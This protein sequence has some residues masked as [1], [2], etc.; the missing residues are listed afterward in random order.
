VG[1]K[2]ILG[3]L[4]VFAVVGGSCVLA[5][6]PS[7]DG[8]A[9]VGA[10]TDALPAGA[11]RRFGTTRLR[12]SGA[13]S[14]LQ[15][16]RDGKKLASGAGGIVHVWEAGSWRELGHFAALQTNS[17]AGFSPDG[18][19]IAVLSPT[20]PLP[21]GG[22]PGGWG[23]NAAAGALVLYDVESGRLLR[24]LAD[25]NVTHFAFDGTGSRLIAGDVFGGVTV[26]DA[27]GGTTVAALTDK[28]PNR[29]KINSVWQVA[30]SPDGQT[31]VSVH[32]NGF[33]ASI[34]VWDVA[35]HGERLQ[36]P[37]LQGG[38]LDAAF[39]ADGNT[40]YTLF[41][42]RTG[43]TIVPASLGL[44][45]LDVTRGNPVKPIPPSTIEANG[46]GGFAL[47]AIGGI[48]SA[49][50]KHY[51]FHALA[52]KHDGSFSP[53]LLH[54]VSVVDVGS[55]AVTPME[56]K[57]HGAQAIAFSPAGD[58]LVAGGTDGEIAVW[59]TGTGKRVEAPGPTGA[60]HAVS[61]SPDGQYVAAAGADSLIHVM[62]FA[63]GKEV[64]LWK[65]HENTVL[66][67]SFS[68]DGKSL[69]SAGL[70]NAVRIWD[71]ASGQSQVIRMDRFWQPTQ[72]TIAWSNDGK[73][74]AVANGPSFDTID[75]VALRPRSNDP[76]QSPVEFAKDLRFYLPAEGLYNGPGYQQLSVHTLTGMKFRN[77]GGIV[78]PKTFAWGISAARHDGKIVAAASTDTLKLLDGS[79]FQEVLTLAPKAQFEKDR[80]RKWFRHVAFTPDGR[81]LIAVQDAQPW[82]GW[83]GLMNDPK[84]LGLPEQ[85]IRL[86]DVVTGEEKLHLPGGHRGP[87][88]S[89]AFAE[90]G[91]YLLTA[92][93]DSTVLAW[94]LTQQQP[95]EKLPTENGALWAL[96]IGDDAEKAA[97]AMK[98]L[99]ARPADAVSAVKGYFTRPV[100]LDPDAASSL[101]QID[102]P[103]F[104]VRLPAMQRLVRY[105]DS[106][107][108]VESALVRR[109]LDPSVPAGS[110]QRLKELI[111]G[112]GDNKTPELHCLN[113]AIALLEQTG[114]PA[115]REELSLLATLPSSR[116]GLLA[117]QA[118]SRLEH[119]ESPSAP[120]RA[121][122]T[123][124]TQPAIPATPPSRPPLPPPPTMPPVSAG[125][126][127]AVPRPA[128]PVPKSTLVPGSTPAGGE[129]GI[130]V[131]NEPPVTTGLPAGAL[132]R[133]GGG[134][135]RMAHGGPIMTLSFCADGNRLASASGDQTAKVWEVPSGKELLHINC[136][137]EFPT[138]AL[139]PDG[140]RVAVT[141]PAMPLSN[142]SRQVNSV[143]LY[144][145]AAGNSG[146]SIWETHDSARV[147]SL[148]FSHDGNIL[149]A[150]TGDGS[151]HLYDATSGK[152][153]DSLDVEVGN[154]GRP[155]RPVRFIRFSDDDGAILALCAGDRGERFI[156]S[157]AVWNSKSKTL[158]MNY[159]AQADPGSLVHAP[160]PI[161]AGFNPAGQLL[162][163]RS[164][165]GPNP[166]EA[167]GRLTVVNLN[168]VF[169]DDAWSM[170]MRAVSPDGKACIIEDS[171]SGQHPGR[172]Y[173]NDGTAGQVYLTL[174]DVKTGQ[175]SQRLGPIESPEIVP[176]TPG[177]PAL[178]VEAVEFSPDG[179]LLAAAGAG[180]VVRL[181]D[182]K[183]GKSLGG[184]AGGAVSAIALSRDGK[185]LAMGGVDAVVS[186]RSTAGDPKVK[187]FKAHAT[188][189]SAL[190]LS[191]DGARL[192]S[193][194]ADGT[195]KF[196]KLPEV[197]PIAGYN[198]PE[199]VNQRTPY[200]SV[201]AWSPDGRLVAGSGTGIG[202]VWSP[203]SGT[204][205]FDQPLLDEGS[206]V[207]F[208]GDS[209]L[210]L[211]APG[212]V[213]RTDARAGKI[214]SKDPPERAY[215]RGGQALS[216]DGTRYAEVRSGRV[217]VADVLC[218]THLFT[219]EFND[220]YHPDDP[221]G[222]VTRATRG[223]GFSPDGR[224]LALVEDRGLKRRPG[225]PESDHG[226]AV[227]H[228]WDL[229]SR[230]EIV[231]YEGHDGQAVGLVFSPTGDRI[232]T[233]SI[234]GTVLA[235]R[236]PDAPTPSAAPP[237]PAGGELFTVLA[238]RARNDFGSQE[239]KIGEAV[240]AAFDAM[241]AMAARPDQAIT[242]IRE[243]YR[244]SAEP[245]AGIV[246]LIR[247]LDNA[248][249]D[250]L[251]D[252]TRTLV[253][254]EVQSSESE[255]A[256]FCAILDPASSPVL[257]QRAGDVL[258]KFG[259][260]DESYKMFR[261]IIALEQMKSPAAKTLLKDMAD[262]L[263]PERGG[264]LARR[265]FGQ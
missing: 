110:K 134:G 14:S 51:A 122:A 45:L 154:S 108:E 20:P 47:P 238:G 21:G 207:R 82:D 42:V 226:K 62:A 125:H 129:L 68:P 126:D 57:I 71:V 124:T 177:V 242:A 265:A 180:G 215:R 147:T 150:G 66:A 118:L 157:L 86:Y 97:D 39:S 3:I 36:T 4:V 187:R 11:F 257:R 106:N 75:V 16:S 22:P 232:Y 236:V 1:L 233:A 248:A 161:G 168:P 178:A 107:V 185:T 230:K 243:R 146:K 153:V 209:R 12:E 76:G 217:N 83:R 197:Q 88:L 210:V 90:G 252:A 260:Y 69:A 111:A 91:K 92:S 254:R 173:V 145:V 181:F 163:F 225:R 149:A 19:S 24:T 151:L 59:Q 115:A 164:T 33:G 195:V 96:V 131:L 240:N 160:M 237:L 10:P 249:P 198:P 184:T 34:H 141:T 172:G 43:T 179:K 228:V 26:Y 259:P 79:T 7:G 63:T 188:Q 138:V 218:R 206:D 81:G 123:G 112:I 67:L 167:G 37:Y 65:G 247:S 121:V 234:D 175:S 214:I 128:T 78:E 159:K 202:R 222:I 190:A 46:H 41:D 114:T 48:F 8:N 25:K 133:Y 244:L 176:L 70:D 49:D 137:A 223:M 13:V 95:A 170:K 56:G 89:L 93:A 55:G 105:R 74:V 189:I 58:L 15:F 32:G 256:L 155:P 5:Q 245:D 183:T 18:H 135:G 17:L 148:A 113:R 201:L 35:T 144:G 73:S 84:K 158:A 139:S 6:S 258:L 28:G 191:G 38:C 102:S 87:I 255:A 104:A 40:H 152:L 203:L 103:T 204:F 193:A 64:A 171:R 23:N 117:E 136:D 253:Q 166:V 219:L 208:A 212:A 182:V 109:Y 156:T 99:A 30:I 94:D 72:C 9:N 264:D 29:N 229:D 263:P 213:Q 116:G 250:V 251:A 119:G 192:A 246:E 54:S 142:S 261:I 80:P 60:L 50:L 227:V 44:R 77:T 205:V 241:R 27:A 98:A 85:V 140:K 186:L 101:E 194:G 235:W 211:L 199:F 130:T 262:R 100:R 31:G 143:V 52:E 162:L 127:P 220:N 120:P 2:F 231:T 53:T 221:A 239:K 200:V 224:M 132:A 174:Q 196:W 169:G 216:V 61:V 165:R